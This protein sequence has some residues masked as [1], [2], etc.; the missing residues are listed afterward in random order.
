MDIESRSLC[1]IWITFD[2]VTRESSGLEFVRGSQH[3]PE[4]FKAVTPNYD[5]YMMDSE[6]EDAP[7]ID[8]NRDAYDLFCP[9]MEPGDALIFNAHIMHGSSSNYSTDKP[10]RAFASRWSGDGVLFED[11]H[12]TMPLLWNHGLV[13]GDPVGGSL[14]PQVLPEPIEAE[15]AR[16]ARGPEPPEPE[17]VKRVIEGLSRAATS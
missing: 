1:S 13:N 8:A 7:N 9:D 4:R 10:R 11:R 12:A 2:T 14:F 15:S 5:P 3:W 16:R 17:F 6:Y